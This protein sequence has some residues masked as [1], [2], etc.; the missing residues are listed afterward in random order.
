MH[1][2]TLLCGLLALTACGT[3]SP[4]RTPGPGSAR[5][6]DRI[7]GLAD[8]P[9]GS[10]ALVDTPGG[11]QLLLVRPADTEVRAFNPACPHQGTVVN[12]PAGGAI[13]CP[14]HRSEFD[15]ATGAVTRGP[16]VKGL[17][18]VAVRLAGQDVLLA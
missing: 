6:G 14:T 10:G 18:E 4:G 7:A 11:G 2:R 9:V 5:P 16:A 3:P 8:L 13:V 15:P 1:R 17:A 12:P